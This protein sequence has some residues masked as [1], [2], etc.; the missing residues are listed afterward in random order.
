MKSTPSKNVKTTCTYCGVGC[1][2]LATVDDQG[3]VSVKGDP[4]HPANF[5]RLCSKGINL[6]ETM[7]ADNRLLYPEINGQRASW[8]QSLDL[9][10]SKFTEAIK[11]HGPD[12]VAIYGS[13]QLLTE[14]YYVANKL[15]KGFVGSANIDTNSRLCMASSV[16]GHIR[17]FGSDTVPGTY[18]DLE[19]CDLL[20]LVG[21][22]LAWCHPVL[23]QRI[24]AAKDARPEM[25]I[26][27]IDPRRTATAEIADLHLALNADGDT[28]LFNGLLSY[29]Q[30]ND[31]VDHTYIDNYTTGFT[32]AA[33]AAGVV[34][35]ND[36]ARQ[37]GLPKPQIRKFYDLYVSTPKTVT[38][39]SQG[40][41]QSVSG[42]DKVNSILN[43]H[44]A[45]GR[46]GKVGMGPFSIT[47]QPN[48]MGGR[49][50]GGLATQLA[51]HMK[52]DD[53]DHRDLVQEYWKSP[54]IAHKAGLKAVDLF[55]A[56]AEGKI[57]VVW[58]LSTNPVVSMP[59]A[60]FV[61]NALQQ[62]DFVIASDILSLTDTVKHAHVK[63]PSLGWGEKQGTVTNSERRIS[64][65]KAFLK[66]PGDAKADWWQLA[67]IGKRMGFEEA[68][69][70]A[71][72][73]DVFAEHAGLSGYKNEGSRD[74]DISGLANMTVDEYNDFQPVQWPVNDGVS[75]A[76]FFAEGGF[77]TQT[78][79]ANFLP[80][81]CPE[82]R[83]L[84]EEYPL[85]LNTG[86]IR[87]QWHTMTRTGLA[88]KLSA[89]LAEPFAEIHP[90][91][92]KAYGISDAEIACVESAYGTVI[93]RALIT[94]RVRAGSV[95][96]PIHWNDQFSSKAR[97]DA[98]VPS[99]VDPHSGQPAFKNTPVKI[100][101]SEIKH[102]AYAIGLSEPINPGAYY[103]SKSKCPG[104]WQVE[105]AFDRDVTDWQGYLNSLW[106][107]SPSSGIE[108]LVYEDAFSKE[109]R[110]AIFENDTLLG[111]LYV[112]KT[113]VEVSR[114]WVKDLLRQQFV[115]FDAKNT[116]LAGRPGQG[117][118]EKGPI[119]CSCFDVGAFQIS[120]AAES[121]CRTVEAVG[122]E[123]SAG[124]NCGS[125]RS[126]IQ[127][128]INQ[129]S[130]EIQAAE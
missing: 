34:N 47:G 46:I 108:T 45:T 13:G 23:F 72:E 120:H 38:A 126:E 12:S 128:L 82:P 31:A 57:K 89:H 20:V 74:F 93:V 44:L 97:V 83:G 101:K 113:P 75:K 122:S 24:Q 3:D 107:L 119:I 118:E 111:A 17:A 130:L 16:M 121:G 70:Y 71:M 4:D 96:V 53:P 27:V 102:F 106:G 68:F 124:T 7:D 42:T 80:V 98:L 78:G 26:V 105:L 48:A 5:G 30:A 81:K 58:I 125:C 55:Q 8:D 10:A 59:N 28:A 129:S 95:F 37:T 21:S 25:T 60:D 92:A 94:D 76:R 18:E 65:Q 91:D 110:I 116:V 1:G 22:N 36:L 84:N 11:E 2:I 56:M 79:K 62:C 54:V 63:L 114:S 40:V 112:S 103:W 29:L 52:L 104:G 14:D 15:M 86:R 115:G 50:V 9:I 77:Y 49:E 90:L 43:C 109:N 73:A 33:T 67:E 88:S 35:F 41:N 99:R 51:A 127:V 19:L 64:L 117:V 100:Y 6:G 61:Q 32:S 69:D 39:F 87:D 123:L 66:G 85:L